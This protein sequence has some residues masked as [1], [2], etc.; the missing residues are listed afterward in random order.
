[1]EKISYR[2]IASGEQLDEADGNGG[3][4]FIIRY[5]FTEE[6]DYETLLDN[7]N[8]IRTFDTGYRGWTVEALEIEIE[9]QNQS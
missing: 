9:D 1:M 4:V 8:V 3:R 7:C 2:L 6:F 5:P